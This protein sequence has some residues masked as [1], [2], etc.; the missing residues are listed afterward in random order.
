MREIKYS[1]STPSIQW[2]IITD[3]LS[4]IKR[5]YLSLFSLN[6]IHAR[7]SAN[8]SI[9]RNSIILG[10]QGGAVV[11]IVAS[12][13]E[14][15]GFESR[16]WPFLCRVCVFS[17]VRAGFLPQSKTMLVRCID[18]SKLAIGMSVSGFLSIC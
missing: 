13:Q 8:T 6:G 10:W 14:R 3:A 11:S 7:M 2:R 12:R 9:K 15:L 17:H 5:S 18:Q 16:F 4:C 1:S